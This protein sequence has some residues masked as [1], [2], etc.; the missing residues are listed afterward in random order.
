M[1]AVTTALCTRLNSSGLASFLQAPL[2]GRFKPPWQRYVPRLIHAMFIR[3]TWHLQLNFFFS[4][5]F[6]YFVGYFSSRKVVFTLFLFLLYVF[7]FLQEDPNQKR[8]RIACTEASRFASLNDK[9]VLLL[10][11]AFLRC[12]RKTHLR[13]LIGFSRFFKSTTFRTLMLSWS[14]ATKIR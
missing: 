3:V 14:S 11:K 1:N 5:L 12:W 4:I 7:F 10:R 2:A 13:T 8:C 9:H 6:D